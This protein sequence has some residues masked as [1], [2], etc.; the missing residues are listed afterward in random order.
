[1]T[2][3]YQKIIEEE[4][5]YNSKLFPKKDILFSRGKGAL[6]YDV[7][8]NEYLDCVGGHGVMNIG[9]SHPKYIEKIQHQVEELL[10]VPQGYPVEE[11]YKLL[12]TLAEI[13]PK[14]LSQ[15]FLSNS[16]T[17]SIEAAI[18]LVLAANRDIKNPEIIAFKRSFHGRTLGS[19]ALTY[20]MK[21]RKAFISWLSPHV[22]WASFGD[23]ESV[24]ELVN[25]NT[26]AVFIEMIQGEGGVYPASE[27]FI[28]EL[29][30]LCENG[31]LIL[32]DDEVQTGFG[33]TG[34]MFAYEHYNI[35]PDVICMAKGIAGGLPMGATISSSELFD[36]MM[37]GEHN[38]TFGGNPLCCAAANAVIDIIRSENLV[39]NAEKKG[40]ELIKAFK[41]LAEDEAKR[42]REVRG[43]GLM[44]GI[45]YRMKIKNLLKKAQ[46]MKLLLLNAGLTTLR[47]IPPLVI[48]DQQVD[49]IIKIIQQ[50]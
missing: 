46:E 8:G 1:M 45:D 50:L 41:R 28:K 26:V 20:T 23:I 25:E 37:I 36:K 5:F 38:T 29:K 9:H 18:K 14:P 48:D 43:I 32:V 7:N 40:K 19:L 35:I 11:R 39:K 24:K 33:R 3:N 2:K 27:S 15:T 22:K 31:D 13:T 30:E 49:K 17:E 42:I 10:L 47:L 4:N 6:L 34:K 44:I 21:Y 12:K 16:G